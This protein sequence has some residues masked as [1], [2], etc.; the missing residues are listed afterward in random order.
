MTK[1]PV[2]FVRQGALISQAM[3]L[4]Q[5]TES[6]N[7]KVAG[8][9]K[10]YEKIISDKH[11]DPMAKF[12]A[13]L[14][15]G[16]IDAGMVDLCKPVV[17]MPKKSIARWSQRYNLIIISHRSREHACNSGHGCLYAV[18]VLVP[19]NTHAKLGFYSHCY[20]WPQQELTG[21]TNL[22]YIHIY[23]NSS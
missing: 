2:D 21:T 13:V 1:D 16:I 19:I 5:Q 10:L 4:I 20:H 23:V 12:G 14:G 22:L 6:T 18:L 11:E 8:V 15:Q 17:T 3:I 9:R 7:P